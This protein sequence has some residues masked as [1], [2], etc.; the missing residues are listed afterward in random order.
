[1]ERAVKV[2]LSCCVL[3]ELCI[4]ENDDMNEYIEDGPSDLEEVNNCVEV[5]NPPYTAEIK[6]QTIV[7]ILTN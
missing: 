2:S 1:M 4:E 6:R 3:H 5:Q 7:D